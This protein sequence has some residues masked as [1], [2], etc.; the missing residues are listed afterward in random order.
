[1]STKTHKTA[2]YRHAAFLGDMTLDK[3][4]VRLSG[5]DRTDQFM[6]LFL[7]TFAPFS[8]WPTLF[9]PYPS[10]EGGRVLSRIQSLHHFF[11]IDRG[12]QADHYCRVIVSLLDS[13]YVP[14]SRMVERE[15][16]RLTRVAERNDRRRRMRE[17]RSHALASR[18][19]KSDPSS[20]V[21]AQ[22]VS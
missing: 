9:P 19:D 22:G 5:R 21:Y 15:S 6:S 11:V 14:T 20:W 12:W 13:G 16:D 8:T 1:M 2:T 10:R 7:R 18:P 17:R 4:V 3:T